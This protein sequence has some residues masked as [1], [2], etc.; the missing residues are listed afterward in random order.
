MFKLRKKNH[1]NQNVEH[2]TLSCSD[3][4]ITKNKNSIEFGG[5][6]YT[7]K[8]ERSSRVSARKFFSSS[9][10]S[11]SCKFI[12]LLAILIWAVLVNAQ[13]VISKGD[14]YGILDKQSSPYIIKSD[15]VVPNGQT[16]EIMPGVEV[17]FDGMHKIS[18]LGSL[19]AIGYD[20]PESIVFNSRSYKIGKD[21][22]IITTPSW[23]G[24]HF[25]AA[26]DVELKNVLF[27]H[28]DIHH[29]F[30]IEDSDG[31]IIENC[32]FSDNYVSPNS[33][34]EITS[35]ITINNSYNVLL[36]NNIYKNISIFEDM[37]IIPTPPIPHRPAIISWQN[38]PAGTV[39]S[40][41]TFEDEV[42]LS[43][44]WIQI[45][46]NNP[47]TGT[48]TIEDCVFRNISSHFGA[49]IAQN[50]STGMTIIVQENHFVN[51]KIPPHPYIEDQLYSPA[52]TLIGQN[53]HVL[54]N[55]MSFNSGYYGG[56]I[57]TRE[58][59]S[60]VIIAQN[61]I[62][63]NHGQRGGAIYFHGTSQNVNT[64]QQVTENIIHDNYFGFDSQ[65]GAIHLKDAKIN[66]T[67]PSGLPEYVDVTNGLF[68]EHNSVFNNRGTAIYLEDSEA[69]LFNNVIFGN[70]HP[71]MNVESYGIYQKNTVDGDPHKRLIV[72][73]SILW[74]NGWSDFQIYAK[75]P[76]LLD[77]PA[78][79][80]NTVLSHNPGHNLYN[81]TTSI[82]H[83]DPMFADIWGFDFRVRNT[84]YNSINTSNFVWEYDYVGVHDH[85]ENEVSPETTMPIYRRE[86]FAG[87][88]W[89]SFPMLPRYPNND[90][91]NFFDVA[92]FLHDE[93]EL[94][95]NS[96]GEEAIYYPPWE[97]DLM[98]FYSVEGYI[99]EMPDPLLTDQF[100]LEMYEYG[101][102]PVPYKTLPPTAYLN[103]QGNTENWVGY[104]LKHT[105]RLYDAFTSWVLEDI[106]SI[107]IQDGGIYYTLSG[108]TL[109]SDA[110]ELR[111]GYGDMAKVIPTE[112][113]SFQWEIGPAPSI[114]P[115][116]PPLE[117]PYIFSYTITPH[118]LSVFYEF[119]PEDDEPYPDEIGVFVD[120]V[121]KGATKY[122]KGLMEI[123]VYLTDDDYGKEMVIVYGYASRS[124]DKIPNNLA[125]VN[126]E[127]NKALEFKPIIASQSNLYYHISSGNNLPKDDTGNIKPF[128]Q[129]HSNYPNPFNPVTNISFYLS[130]EE[131]ISLS[132]YNIKGQKVFDLHKGVLS[133]GQHRLQWN[134]TDNNNREVASGIYFYKLTTQNETISKKMLLLK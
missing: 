67:L 87:P 19:I 70:K 80:L 29:G 77:I 39:I 116:R 40:G 81:P 88:N 47:N 86:L 22:Y 106:S 76:T 3:T 54:N 57:T 122:H 25:S 5:K 8:R 119:V 30:I 56:G 132:I 108:E 55:L 48:V 97:G 26:S 125:L 9:N 104:F 4:K 134:G 6:M 65:S 85:K 69:V 103:L 32:T 45:T 17:I 121:C 99:I 101:D 105:V 35:F 41:Q 43:A 98:N 74:Q 112:D 21:D 58:N 1:F 51:N 131:N 11:M 91:A 23:K 46:A 60:N 73:N 111:I 33:A 100:I 68:I 113:L 95:K 50:Y 44:I 120:D 128:A 102:P 78:I 62:Y 16:L 71:G 7:Q 63:Q 15:I 79:I 127:K 82:V 75:V 94:I 66:Y 18:V 2:D 12:I 14:V 10:R 49:V 52:L 24:I 89:I 109:T 114:N 115:P 118:Y 130:H 53:I 37:P 92:L 110:K 38:P 107:Q 64:W 36:S 34:S 31:V 133:A 28:F 126:H 42:Y 90:P 84:A 72:L 83:H 27:K 61:E 13:T 59:G 123:L 93:A 124:P 20:E 129:L 117:Q 96:Y